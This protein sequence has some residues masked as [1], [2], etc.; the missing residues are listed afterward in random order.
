[1]TTT[2]PTLNETLDALARLTG[3]VSGT[4]HALRGSL[5]QAAD[6][7]RDAQDA[8]VGLLARARPL[9]L[10]DMVGV[11]AESVTQ[12]EVDRVEREALRDACQALVDA[13]AR[14]EDAGGSMRWDDVDYAHRLAV[15]ALGGKGPS[16]ANAG[17][18][19][20]A[21]GPCNLTANPADFDGERPLVLVNVVDGVAEVETF[22]LGELSVVVLD[23][24]AMKS[25]DLDPEDWEGFT[26]AEW[27]ALEAHAS[28]CI[29]D[30]AERGFTR[31]EEPTA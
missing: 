14:G 30:L 31:S 23:W 17:K 16:G 29:T 15:D 28:G 25:G 6:A 10:A 21:L 12:A 18:P 1:M 7:I 4:T 24:D 22:D 13:Y 19:A 5:P 20:W 9:F 27:A 11:P 3:A 8:A 26:E 2:L